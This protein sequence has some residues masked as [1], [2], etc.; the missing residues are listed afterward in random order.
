MGTLG[1]YI[2]DKDRDLLDDEK[3][4][5]FGTEVLQKNHSKPFFLTLGYH[6]PHRPL[7]VPKEFFDRYD[8]ETIKLPPFKDNDLDDVPKATIQY[9]TLDYH[10]IIKAYDG[11]EGWKL[12]LQAYLASISFVDEEIGKVWKVLQSSPYADNTIVVITSDHGYH[13]FEKKRLG[14]STLWERSTRIPLLI[15]LPDGQS[16][17]KKI[18][19]PVSLIDIYP[20]L[21]DYCNLERGIDTTKFQKLDGF[22]LK[23]LI[24]KPKKHHGKDPILHFLPSV[25]QNL[26][27]PLIRLKK[28][29]IKYI[30]LERRVLGMYLI[31]RGRKNFMITILMKM[32]ST[33]LRIL[34]SIKSTKIISRKS[35]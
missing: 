12:W 13:N 31:I 18:E 35:C 23:P 11:L 10:R 7:Y 27:T 20:T 30:Q 32:N 17:G 26:I 8:K 4:T 21:V 19:H 24:D 29:K 3:T 34:K 2:S 14:K 5:L 22:S 6:R 25:L 33:T 15:I 9:D 1:T 16:R 28:S